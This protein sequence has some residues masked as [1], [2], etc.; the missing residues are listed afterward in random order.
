MCAPGVT[1]LCVKVKW[2]HEEPKPQKMALSV[3]Y[4]CSHEYLSWTHVNECVLVLVHV[5]VYNHVYV[6]YCVKE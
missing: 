5:N 6:C 1:T 2:D 3:K 4:V